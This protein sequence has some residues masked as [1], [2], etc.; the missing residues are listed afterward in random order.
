MKIGLLSALF[1]FPHREA[2]THVH[3][4]AAIRI[5]V[6]KLMREFDVIISNKD[7]Y[8][9]ILYIIITQHV[10]RNVSKSTYINT[11]IKVIIN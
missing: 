8:I 3:I 1:R 4:F 7:I 11:D 6:N 9:Y 5:Y 2:T 10:S